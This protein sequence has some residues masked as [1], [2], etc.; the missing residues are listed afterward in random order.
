MKKMKAREYSLAQL[1]IDA[2][3]ISPA[4][5]ETVKTLQRKGHEA[6]LVGGAVRDLL[7]GLDPKDY[8]VATSATPQQIKRL[9]RRAFII[10]RRFRLVHVIISRETI[11]VATFRKAPG[12]TDSGEE[13]SIRQD[14]NT[15]GTSSEDALRRDLTIN[16]LMLDPVRKRVLD[17]TDGIKDIKNRTLRVIGVPKERY[18]EDPVR[19]MRLLRLSARLG[20]DVSPSSLRVVKGLS[21]ALR[22]IPP[23]RLFDEFTKAVFSEA[24]RTAFSNFVEHGIAHELFPHLR[25]FDQR[26]FDFIDEALHSTDQISRKHEHGSLSFV[27]STLFWPLVSERW[28]QASEKNSAKMSLMR[29]LYADCQIEESKI[30][31]RSLRAKVW[32]IWEY[33]SRF[34]N[35]KGKRKAL[36]ID[37][38][39]YAV[40]KALAFLRLRTEA[41]EI[42]PDLLEWWVDFFD[43]DDSEKSK[44]LQ[45]STRRGRKR[46]ERSPADEGTSP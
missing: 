23:A 14:D 22:D 1:G 2:G 43:Q 24:S 10:G 9:F 11:E 15:Y 36:K 5:L 26:G 8:D 39:G 21:P 25:D 27:V 40:R 6:Y 7:L 20:Y 32:E 3:K 45:S 30:V 29:E 4:S 41:G 46:K 44:R 18:L 12:K 19:M 16:A 38:R 33:Q 31:P 28:A 13:G 17:Y 35:L 42:G 37:P 34:Q